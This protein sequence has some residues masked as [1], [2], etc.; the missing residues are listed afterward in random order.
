MSA[1]G[2]ISAVP[3]SSMSGE[4]GAE[5]DLA[6]D[7]DADADADADADGDYEP[8]LYE[9]DRA[10]TCAASASILSFQHVI[11]RPCTPPHRSRASPTHASLQL[12]FIFAFLFAD[13]I[14]SARR[15][16]SS[17]GTAGSQR[18][19]D[20]CYSGGSRC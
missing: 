1:S 15:D 20:D 7:E 3:S 2:V 10:R 17:W 4:V 14:A 6:Y 11:A 19:G 13:A 8:E 16:G 9:A 12:K 5:V 18:G